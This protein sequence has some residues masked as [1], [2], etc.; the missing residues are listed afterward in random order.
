MTD[1]NHIEVL[2]EMRESWAELGSK[3]YDKYVAACDAAITALSA[4]ASAGEGVP[5]LWVSRDALQQATACAN[6]DRPTVATVNAWNDPQ[7]LT[8]HD[9]IALYTAAPQPA[10]AGASGGELRAWVG[11][12][13]TSAGMD[14]YV[15][16]GRDT[17]NPFDRTYLTPNKYSIRGRAEYDVAEWNHL[18][19]HGPKPDILAFDTDAT[20]PAHGDGEWLG[21]G[22]FYGNGSELPTLHPDPL[23]NAE[24]LIQSL[25]AR[26][27]TARQALAD[28][29]AMQVVQPA[30]QKIK[31]NAAW[32]M[33][34]TAPSRVE[35][36]SAK[37][38]DD[39]EA[40]NG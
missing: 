19:G 28:A 3:A 11:D 2:R 24:I 36:R 15:C 12:M 32:A 40:P 25:C 5:V 21:T 26:L 23:T 8:G 18:L 30:L 14:Y 4:R 35:P 31:A 1:T 7:R 37:W 33:S 9:P 39:E 17:G 20:P 38:N 22:D 6:A 10:Q 16:V 29:A 34:E 27:D 13:K